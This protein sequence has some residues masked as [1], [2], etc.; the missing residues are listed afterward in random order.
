MALTVSNVA[1]RLQGTG[2]PEM[3][4]SVLLS[5]YR[6]EKA[7]YLA[8]CLQS[9]TV[10]T[11]RATEVVLVEDGPISSGLRQVIERFRP[12]LP[13]TSVSLAKNVGLAAALNAGLSACTNE[14]VARMDTDDV[15]VPER[16]AKQISFMAQHAEVSVCGSWVWEM[17]QTMQRR[18]FE[19]RLPPDHETLCRFA[20]RRNPLNHP[21]C[22]FRAADVRAVGGYP[23]VFPEDYAL[24]SLMLIKGY[25]LANLEEPLLLMRTG[26]DFIDRR[27]LSF[28]R[29]EFSLVKY[30]RSIGF[31]SAIEALVFMGSRVALRLAPATVRRFLYRFSR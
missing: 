10:Q 9:L 27:G 5:V 3:S 13:I 7:E 6:G 1:H 11:H 16:F 22:I 29:R 24:W 31:F 28:L 8:E 20:K 26:A 14:L 25:R 2:S 17:D 12:R 23:M 21:S 18:L 15:A 19:K 30:Q 4:L